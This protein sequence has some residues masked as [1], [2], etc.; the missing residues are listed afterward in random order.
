LKSETLIAIGPLKPMSRVWPSG[1]DLATKSAPMLPP[2]PPLFS[3]ITGWPSALESSGAMRRASTS[4]VLPTI[5][6]MMRTV[7]EGDHSCA[8]PVFEKSRNTRGT[9]RNI[10]PSIISSLF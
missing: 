8:A 1:S 6:T 3:T 9:K 2:P 4:L 10:L 5:G 7:L